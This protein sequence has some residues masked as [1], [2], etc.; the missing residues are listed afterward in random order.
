MV[1]TCIPKIVPDDHV[2]PWR[3]KTVLN[4]TPRPR[5][6]DRGCNTALE[7]QKSPAENGMLKERG[8][9]RESINTSS[10]LLAVFCHPLNSARPVV[11]LGVKLPHTRLCQH[12]HHT[13]PCLQHFIRLTKYTNAHSL[14]RSL[15]PSPR[16]TRYP[17][18]HARS[19]AR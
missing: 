13:R 9:E 6:H 14:S 15:V 17:P 1:R 7:A 11:G 8:M 2:H 12:T 19:L 18:C 4:K 3:R 10:V 5:P 16:C